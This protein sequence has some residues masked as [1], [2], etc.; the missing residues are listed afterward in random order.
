MVAVVISFLGGI[1]A[2]TKGQ[3]KDHQNSNKMMNFRVFF[4]G[5]AILFLLLSFVAK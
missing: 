2:M 4:Q 5:L 3:K 1:I